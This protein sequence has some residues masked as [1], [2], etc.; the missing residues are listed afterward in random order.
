MMAIAVVAMMIIALPWIWMLHAK[1]GVWSTGSAGSLNLSWYLTGTPEYRADLGALLPPPYPDSPY[2]WEDPFLVNGRA[3]HFWDSPHLFLLQG[4]RLGYNVLKFF[5]SIGELSGFGLP[6]WIFGVSLLFSK[7]L[8]LR[9][10]NITVLLGL[11]CAFFPLLY[12]LINFESRYLWYLVPILMVL[13]GVIIQ[14]AESL[15]EGRLI[16][17]LSIAF[18][19]SFMIWPVWKMKEIT[20]VGKREWRMAREL[21]TLGIRGPFVSNLGPGDEGAQ[22]S[23]GRLAYFSGNSWYPAAFPNTPMDSVLADAARYNVRYL[24]YFDKMDG[25]DWVIPR[26][27]SG[28]ALQEITHSRIAGL[29]VFLLP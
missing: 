5:I 2:H 6:L 15:Q 10:S 25:K 11:Q 29:R 27:N 19:I 4:V 28:E 14:H 17:L 23:V 7:K 8:R 20:G 26:N 21:K 13:G 18:T 12:F 16:R 24:Y 22:A 9:F 1:Y 3:L